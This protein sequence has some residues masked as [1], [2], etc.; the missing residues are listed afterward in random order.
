[1]LGNF[2]ENFLKLTKQSQNQINTLLNASLRATQYDA[3]EHNCEQFHLLEGTVKKNEKGEYIFT[4]C[5]VLQKLLD[6]ADYPLI[7]KQEEDRFMQLIQLVLKDIKNER[8][9]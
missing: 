4:P 7:L 3:F 8:D 9:K 2:K 5:D 1:M 6:K